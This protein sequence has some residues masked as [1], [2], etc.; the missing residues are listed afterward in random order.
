[1]H[2]AELSAPGDEP[3]RLALSHAR[4][5]RETRTSSTPLVRRLHA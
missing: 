3:G 2:P 5:K 1:V 4:T